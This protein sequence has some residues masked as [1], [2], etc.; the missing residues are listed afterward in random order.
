ML[1]W[2]MLQ[3]DR[4]VNL[5]VEVSRISSCVIGSLLHGKNLGLHFKFRNCSHIRNEVCPV[6]LPLATSKAPVSWVENLGSFPRICSLTAPL[7]TDSAEVTYINPTV[8]QLSVSV[9]FAGFLIGNI[10]ILEY[11]D[12]SYWVWQWESGGRAWVFREGK[13]DDQALKSGG[14]IAP[15]SILG[16]EALSNDLLFSQFC[17]F[18][19][20]LLWACSCGLIPSG[21]WAGQEDPKVFVCMSKS[22]CWLLAGCLD[23][24]LFVLTIRRLTQLLLLQWSL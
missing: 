10:S 15:F 13:W 18:L 21:R 16:N 23:S 20:W 14:L 19:C 2:S 24:P 7:P 22:W 11:S 4:P 9:F 6:T 8:S 12:D 1:W 3:V 5:H 17:G